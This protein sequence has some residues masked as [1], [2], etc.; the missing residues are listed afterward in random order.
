MI[1]THYAVEARQAHRSATDPDSMAL[2]DLLLTFPADKRR[3]FLRRLAP[4]EL[5]RVLAAV[6]EQRRTPYAMWEDTPSGFAEDVLGE[7][8]NA[9]QAAA[10]D[11]VAA[12]PRVAAA[13]CFG[14]AK[15]RLSAALMAW[16]AVV[17]P[18]EQ[19]VVV[20]ASEEQALEGV[21]VHVRRWAATAGLPGEVRGN[22][23][24]RETGHWRTA[25][26]GL[27]PTARHA[28]LDH[29][30]VGLALAVDAGALTAETGRVLDTMGAAAHRLVAV[31]TPSQDPGS[32]FEGFAAR[33]DT[34]TARVAVA[35]LRARAGEPE[36]LCTAC[37]TSPA[38][39][40]TVHFPGDWAAAQ[41]AR[42]GADHPRV[43]AQVHA[44][45][46]RVE[47][48]PL[49]GLRPGHPD[50]DSARDDCARG[51]VGELRRVRAAG[52]PQPSTH[53]VE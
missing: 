40:V 52:P 32:W 27:V 5:R 43:R 46:P 37:P 28:A 51:V 12:H 10:L 39:P 15:T 7:V 48:H 17:D 34:V 50:F 3:A 38:H 9:G 45:F 26:H 18:T 2:A 1:P 8:L 21:W 44:E 22:N 14:G 29:I 42:Y 13:V 19:P 30:P 6:R 31:G 49:L 11:A 16:A 53:H 47:L 35:D 33:P 24:Y 41:I 25:A 23:W 4:D 36:P 20:V